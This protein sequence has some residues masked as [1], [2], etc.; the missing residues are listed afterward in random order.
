LQR[1]KN[2]VIKTDPTSNAGNS[3]TAFILD[4][5]TEGFSATKIPDKMGMR[6]SD[7]G[8]L[9]FDNVKIPEKNILL[10]EG[11]GAFVLMRGLNVE[12]LLG[13]A[14]PIGIMQAV[15]DTAFPYVHERHQF[16]KPVGKNQLM[17]G[18]MAEMYSTLAACRA[19]TYTMLKAAENNVDDMS[20]HDCAALVYY[21]SEKC[22]QVALEGIQMLGG[23]GYINDYPVGRYLRDAKLMEIGAGTTEVRKI[24]LGRYFNE[25]FSE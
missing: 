10:G 4:T 7:T 18:K 9:H 14:L 21:V 2:V 22:V 12:R 15:I 25:I 23:N 19:Y 16:G 24:I 17:Q 13:A 8:S 20:N 5:K 1:I 3:I 6:G 11:A